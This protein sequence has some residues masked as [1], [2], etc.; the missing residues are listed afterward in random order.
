MR[1]GRREKKRWRVVWATLPA[2]AGVDLAVD[3]T[4]IEHALDEPALRA[5]GEDLEVGHPE[6]VAGREDLDQGS[7]AEA[8]GPREG[9]ARAVE[10]ALGA[11]R[12]PAR[13]TAA[14]QGLPP[15]QRGH[16]AHAL[17]RGG[18]AL[19]GIRGLGQPAAHRQRAAVAQHAADLFPER[20]GLARRPVVAHGLAQQDE[21]A[22][23]PRDGGVEEV[24]LTGQ[25]VGAP[26]LEAVLG[27]EA[28]HVVGH[29]GVGAAA[30]GQAALLEAGHDDDLG[31]M[32]AG[33]A[34]AD[35]AHAS[36]AAIVAH[37]DGQALE[38]AHELVLVGRLRQAG[39]PFEGAV[40]RPPGTDLDGGLT[41]LANPG[42]EPEGRRGGTV[43]HQAQAVQRSLRRA[44]GLHRLHGLAGELPQQ[45]IALV[46]AMPPAAP[47]PALPGIDRRAAQAA[48]RRAQPG[49]EGV[50]VAAQPG[51]AAQGQQGVTKGG[52]PERHPGV[53]RVRHLER[54]QRP[55]EC[56]A[57]RL[58]GREHDQDLVG[59]DAR[60]QQGGHL[61]GDGV[62]LALG[63]RGLEQDDAPVERHGLGCR[64]LGEQPSLQ[65]EQA[66]ARGV[67]AGRKLVH[68]GGP[69]G[70]PLERVAQGGEGQAA[71]L[72]G[73][74]HEHT[75]P[76]G[77]G[78]D[79][80]ELGSGQL[81]EAVDE[82]RVGVPGGQLG[83]RPPP[84]PGEGGAAVVEPFAVQRLM[85][86]VVQAGDL[87]QS[88]CRGGA[89][90]QRPGGGL[91]VG[92]RGRALLGE[93]PE[94]A[95]EAGEP[96][97]AGQPLERGLGRHPAQ[98]RGPHRLRRH[99]GS[100]AQ[101]GGHDV[102]QLLEGEHAPAEQAAGPRG[103]LA[104]HGRHLG[105]VG[106]HQHRLLPPGQGVQEA[107]GED[108]DLA[109][110]GGA[111]EEVE[112]HRPSVRTHFRMTLTALARGSQ[113]QVRLNV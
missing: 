57:G 38:G 59:G 27:Q 99:T 88:R 101:A 86:A 5:L 16:R 96:G 77:D 60:A 55:L 31:R 89:G 50:A 34:Q 44:E 49:E 20:R 108:A 9:P 84:G 100:L 111:D 2:H 70:E 54:G 19:E 85:P 102:A 87:G 75:R 15:G 43:E 29:E 73:Q 25:G 14:E 53:E 95:R 13:Q 23:G 11:G 64:P 58:G 110:S 78:L 32:G 10:A 90:P 107:V 105:R 1:A 61:R 45:L 47:D 42:A 30:A 28:A 37:A 39:Q 21:R 48:G 6:A 24:A 69:G 80:V 8:R 79:Q 91:G 94:G 35:D 106:N 36:R 112:R 33:A 18:G 93:A 41:L 109:A 97:R 74:G 72:V 83:A 22:P 68:R 103:Q 65:G 52:A 92:A 63:P 62:G 51:E 76:G 71:G 3:V 113:E 17:P 82:K 7:V 56:A 12:E 26:Q 4:G 46:P 81:L 104:L 66:L 98:E 67:A 40:D